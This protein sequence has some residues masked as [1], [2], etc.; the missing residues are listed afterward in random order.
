MFRAIPE[1]VVL[2]PSDAVS[3]ERLVA[4][5]AAHNGIVYLRTS[6]PQTPILYDA[7]ERFSIGGC[8]VIRQDSADKATVVAAGVTLHEALKAHE[9]LAAEG[10]AIRIIDLYSIKP[11]DTEALMAAAA[12]TN[13]TLI[14]VEDH[15]PEGGLGDAVLEA[16][17]TE[18]VH[19]HK[20]RR[21]RDTAL[22]E[23]GRTPGTSRYQCQCYCSK[24]KGRYRLIACF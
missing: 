10:I 17:A 5:A 9:T 18:D 22:W 11:V 20:L 12:E 15:Y 16:V 1:A 4:E 8:K 6:R 23:T 13:N 19:V 7:D 2:Y 14:T 3:A 21:Y 24:G